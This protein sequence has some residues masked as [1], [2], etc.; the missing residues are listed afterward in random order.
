MT[1]RKSIIP[2]TSTETVPQSC[3]DDPLDIP[4]FLRRTPKPADPAGK[5]ARSIPGRELER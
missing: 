1:F 5:A 2:S 4:A 3:G